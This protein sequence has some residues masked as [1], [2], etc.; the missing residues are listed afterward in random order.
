MINVDACDFNASGL[1]ALALVSAMI[2]RLE[3]P[4]RAALAASAEAKIGQAD[5]AMPSDV[6]IRKRA[7]GMIRAVCSTDPER[8]QPR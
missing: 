4:Q 1:A 2:E 6:E 3:Q 5:P 8:S 7:V